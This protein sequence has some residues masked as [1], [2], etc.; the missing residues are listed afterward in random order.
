MIARELAEWSGSP[1]LVKGPPML[2]SLDITGKA[3][4]A[5]NSFWIRCLNA[6]SDFILNEPVRLVEVGCL[7]P[8]GVWIWRLAAAGGLFSINPALGPMKSRL[9]E[10]DL[11]VW[12]LAICA[13]PVAGFF[14][15]MAGRVR[16]GLS[17]RLLALLLFVFTFGA[18]SWGLSLS[19]MSTG[20]G[21]GLH[22]F[23]AIF[24]GW[25]FVRL[26]TP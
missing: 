4:I 19:P 23:G 17:M 22:A 5:A 15:T 9:S 3:E 1:I 13:P 26:A 6:V 20:I 25:G 7:F 11:L 18:L 12:M 10:G 21:S 16:A 24:A 14:L 2:T 8:T